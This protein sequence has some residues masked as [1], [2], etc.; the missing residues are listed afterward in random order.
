MTGW[1][2]L[3]AG[4][5]YFLQVLLNCSA[6]RNLQLKKERESKRWIN[7]NSTFRWL[8]SLLNTNQSNL[9]RSFKPP[10]WLTHKRLVRKVFSAAPGQDILKYG[11][12]K[13]KGCLWVHVPL[14]SHGDETL[15]I[16]FLDLDVGQEYGATWGRHLCYSTCAILMRFYT[17]PC[18]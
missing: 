17:Q 3:K 7:R 11:A 4:F 2:C 13:K 15:S 12:H 8:T 16:P 18:N 10:S 1:L 14:N 5:V 9:E 6:L